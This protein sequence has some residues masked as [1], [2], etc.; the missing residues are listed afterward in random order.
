MA[1]GSGPG[2]REKLIRAA[3]E[4]FAARGVEGAQ[5]RE[6]VAL[7]GQHLDGTEPLTDEALF[8]ADLAGTATAPLGAPPPAPPSPRPPVPPV[9]RNRPFPC[10]VT[11]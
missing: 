7:A 9:R 1:G 8:P 3:E 6:I 11:P 10:D 5:P 4:L 2:T